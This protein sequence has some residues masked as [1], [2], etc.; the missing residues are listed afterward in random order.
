MGFYYEYL[1]YVNSFSLQRY[2]RYTPPTHPDFIAVPKAISVVKI[3]LGSAGG[4]RPSDKQETL[5]ILEKLLDLS[6]V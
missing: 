1:L 2:L 3:L 4:V 6:E 5:Q